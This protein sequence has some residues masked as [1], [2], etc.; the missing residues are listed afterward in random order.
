MNIH[1][2][3]DTPNSLSAYSKIV[4]GLSDGLCRSGHNVTI[5]GFISTFD[6]YHGIKVMPLATP[7]TSAE[8][9]FASNINASKTDALICIH[10]AHKYRNRYS[11]MFSPTYFWVPVEGE[12]SPRHMIR[13]LQS[14]TIKGVFSYSNIGK[15]ELESKGISCSVI[16]PGFDPEI[17]TDTPVQH[18]KYS[19]DMY[20]RT[21]DIRTLARMGCLECTGNREGCKYFESERMVVNIGDEEQEVPVNRLDEVRDYVGADF[22]VGYV[23]QNIGTRKKIERLIEAFSKMENKKD[24]MLHLH[25]LPSSLMSA[26]DLHKVA[27]LW[28]VTDRVVFSHGIN[29]VDGISDHAMNLLYNYFDIHATATSYEGFGMP[30]L[31][32]MAVG[33]AQVAPACGTGPELIGENERGLLVPIDC[34]EV[35]EELRRGIVN[36]ESLADSMDTLF[37]SKYLRDNLGGAGKE[38]AKQFTWDKVVAR[39]NEVLV[40][41]E[42]DK[43]KVSNRMIIAT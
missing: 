12:G 27:K 39:W 41:K 38:W 23:G 7:F 32:S 29:P 31:E 11:Q 25:T 10:E 8:D 2:L 40:G 13:D 16:Y 37:I 14:Q 26:I 33:K 42:V 5:T 22:V 35:E 6:N 18:C 17:F 28:N 36:I 19:I 4:R 1:I 3:S 9:Q 21:S 15:K 30:I 20:Q 43:E 24:S 34:M